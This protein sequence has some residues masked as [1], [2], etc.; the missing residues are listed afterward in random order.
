[1]EEEGSPVPPAPPVVDDEDATRA[2]IRQSMSVD[3]SVGREW[4]TSGTPSAAEPPDLDTTSR[5]KENFRESHTR[6]TS[7]DRQTQQMH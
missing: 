4:A 2:A 7:D 1:M 3:C 5:E 6:A